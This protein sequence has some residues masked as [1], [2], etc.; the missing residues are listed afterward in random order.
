MPALS[1]P[2]PT[3]RQ[4]AH[5]EADS[6]SALPPRALPNVPAA[7]RSVD[8]V[9]ATLA[10]CAE[11]VRDD[12]QAARAVA[13]RPHP[14]SSLT[15]ASRVGGLPILPPWLLAESWAS[16]GDPDCRVIIGAA[17]D[18]TADAPPS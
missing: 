16:P 3:V 9:R 5:V 4:R 10:V 7:P 1:I 2:A 14:S 8:T 11:P 13:R 12:Y 6:K 17:A 15:L 18:L